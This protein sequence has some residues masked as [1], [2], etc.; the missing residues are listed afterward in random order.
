MPECGVEKVSKRRLKGTRSTKG[1]IWLAS[2]GDHS[3]II[4]YDRLWRVNAEELLRQRERR[5]KAISW[6]P[7]AQ[8]LRRPIIVV[9]RNDPF[10]T[11][12]LV[13]AYLGHDL[14]LCRR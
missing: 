10:E 12:R 7:M 14:G 11:L 13:M 6:L 4:D 8:V 1:R 3:K 5:P 9:G 2:D